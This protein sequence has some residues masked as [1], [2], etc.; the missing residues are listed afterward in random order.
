MI[1][2]LGS[3]PESS[4][5]LDPLAGEETVKPAIDMRNLSSPIHNE[6]VDEPAITPRSRNR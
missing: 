5:E 1:R 3:A 4:L 6:L 2:S